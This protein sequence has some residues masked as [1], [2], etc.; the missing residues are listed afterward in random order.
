MECGH[1]EQVVA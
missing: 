1:A